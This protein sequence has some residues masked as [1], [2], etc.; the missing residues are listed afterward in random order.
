S[1]KAEGRKQKADSTRKEFAAFCLL[2]SAFWFHAAR[3]D[4]RHL[5][6]HHSGGGRFAAVSKDDHARARDGLERRL[7]Q[8]ALADRSVC[9][10]Q[11]KLPQSLDDLVTAGYMREI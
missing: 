7:V 8:V 10:R 3:I 9:R 11:G 6:H 5:D 2:P 1:Q 4:D